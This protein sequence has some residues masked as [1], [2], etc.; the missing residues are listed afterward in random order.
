[1]TDTPPVSRRMERGILILFIAAGLVM[2]FALALPGVRAAIGIATGTGGFS[3]LTEAPVPTDPGAPIVSARYESAWVISDGLSAGAR[4]LLVSGTA[5]GVLTTVLTV[6]AVMLFF[7]LLLWR[8]PFHRALVVATRVAGASLLIG[9]TL[10]A[11]LGGLGRMMAADELNPAAGDV[12][13]VGSSF[14]PVWA[15]VGLSVLALSVVF[16]YGVRLQRDTEGLV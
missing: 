13:V 2:G 15:L 16:T 14:D 5:A 11:G 12:F 8:R 3:L 1:M 7:F 6:S 9:G 10:S 4:S